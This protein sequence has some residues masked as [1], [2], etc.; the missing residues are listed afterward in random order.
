MAHELG[1]HNRH[2]ARIVIDGATDAEFMRDRFPERYAME[3]WDLLISPT[4]TGFLHSQPRT[5]WTFEMDLRPY[6][7]S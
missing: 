7:E 2:V 1:Q 4:T 5:T 3:L 6:M